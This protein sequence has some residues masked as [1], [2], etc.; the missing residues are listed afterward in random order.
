[1]KPEVE[2]GSS[3]RVRW[4]R[5]RLI[6]KLS[7]VVLVLLCALP[8]ALRYGVE[9]WLNEQ[10]NMSAHIGDV[11]LN[12]FNGTLKVSDVELRHFDHQ[13]LVV[14]LV[15]VKVDWLPLLK[16]RF[17]VEALTLE[18]GAL[19]LTQA[20]DE[21]LVVAG[22]SFTD[23]S[24][25]PPILEPTEEDA[26][27]LWGVHSGQILLKNFQLRYQAPNIDM[28]V[29][30]NQLAIAPVVSWHPEVLTPF[31]ADIVV[32]GGRLNLEGTLSPFSSHTVVDSSLQ[33]TGFELHTLA[34][35]LDQAGF[36]GAMGRLDC[37]V[38]LSVKSAESETHTMTL[39]VAGEVK[40]TALQ[41][42]TVPLFIHRLSAL[43]AGEVEYFFSPSPQLTLT[44]DLHCADVDLDLLAA[45]LKIEQKEL[46]WQGVARL[47][48][49]S[50]SLAGNLS[51]SEHAMQDLEKQRQL[52]RFTQLDIKQL[53]ING[54]EQIS[55]DSLDL[56]GL[57]AFE[58]SQD[59]HST[60]S[61]A[62]E[63]TSLAN[64]V[65]RQLNQLH[66]AKLHL[67]GLNFDLKRTVSG[68]LD[69]QEWFPPAQSGGEGKELEPDVTT[70]ALF[71]IRC[72]EVLV[73]EGS[74]IRVVDSTMNPAVT[75]VLDNI[76]LS[77]DNI[78]TS[79]PQQPSPLTF[80]SMVGR[81]SK[82]NVS[83]YVKPFSPLTDVELV[84]S[85][86]E[87]DVATIS[88]YSEKTI[89]YQLQQGQ[90]SLD[91]TL[92]ITAGVMALASDIYLNK[93]R[94]QPLSA[95]DE[96]N[97][98]KG[99]GLPVNLALSLL[100]DRDGDIHLQL[101]VQGNLNDPSLH[102]GPTLRTAVLRTLHNT[103]ML[104]L[105]PLGIVSKAGGMIG[106]GNALRFERVEFEPATAVMTQHSIEYLA[107]VATLLSERS[108]LTVVVCGC[109][110]EKDRELFMVDEKDEAVLREKR[111]QLADERAVAVKEQLLQAGQVEV[112]QLLLCRPAATVI[113]GVPGVDLTLQ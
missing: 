13:V 10:P 91:F 66:V 100:R 84:G 17:S 49:E 88:A 105:A 62:I 43:W 74:K 107:N 40:M 42:G 97:A 83:G 95:E 65:L 33:L 53:A 98:S 96:A 28:D 85:L 109:F 3:L 29:V 101:P 22:F 7:A 56:K 26:A 52:L 2:S 69:L 6:I 104:P 87:F 80:S 64:L 77:V 20:A 30:V 99:I 23:D 110:T 19:W 24:T 73:D 94:L 16:R 113:S 79:Q 75:V 25:P 9:Y 81:Y 112:A 111:R 90:L 68:A 61:I 41:G 15:T 34:P 102:I 48:G 4:R 60:H 76:V 8:I 54:I 93:L 92:P 21:P 57:S 5:L 36:S 58:R 63:Q 106:I 18:G 50:L 27:A 35:L 44:G 55:T 103:V 11:D 71:A 70:P 31:N 78:D 37:A 32:N 45:G 14:Q 1:M 82:L 59:G 38:Q 39:A 72:D 12:L 89:G 51:L 108:Q 46:S 67:A 47:K 86:R